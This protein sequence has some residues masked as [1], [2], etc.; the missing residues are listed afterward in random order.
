MRQVMQQTGS[1]VARRLRLSM[2]VLV[3]VDLVGGL[4]AVAA[5]VNTW[6]EAWG[7]KALLAA[8]LPMIAAQV[9]LTWL[10]SRSASRGAAV[11]SGLLALACFVSVISGFFDGGLA[12]DELS[13]GLVAFQT[14]LLAVTAAV[15]ALAVL[16]GREI[17]RG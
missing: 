4:L 17:L 3:A 10:A 13:A 1:A 9:L 15:G 16:R 14:L 11:A 8:P 2:A 5:G 7:G 6:G 12:N